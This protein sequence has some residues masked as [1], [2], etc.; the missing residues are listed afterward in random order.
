MRTTM[1]LEEDVMLKLK[2]E[3]GRTGGSFK[4]TVNRVLRDG[5]ALRSRPPRRPFVVQPRRLGL[6]PGL[7][8]D[9]VAELLDQLEGPD[10]R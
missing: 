5:L 3:M 2:D 7:N 4:D 10:H 6:R 8:I 1:T 9:N